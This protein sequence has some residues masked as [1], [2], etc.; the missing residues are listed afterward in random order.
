MALILVDRLMQPTHFE[1]ALPKQAS[2]TPSSGSTHDTAHAA[3]SPA[4]SIL[5]SVPQLSDFTV[6]M[7]WSQAADIN[8]AYYYSAIMLLSS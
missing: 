5:S 4:H 1:Y 6:C 3:T 2:Q 7:N 8:Q